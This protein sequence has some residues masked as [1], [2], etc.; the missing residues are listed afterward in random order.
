M[1][2][3]F[4]ESEDRVI[5]WE[6]SDEY[7][8]Q[9]PVEKVSINVQQLIYDA[10]SQVKFKN[11]D[12]AN[13]YYERIL[14]RKGVPFKMADKKGKMDI[15]YVF[16]E[17][18]SD[19]YDY[20]AAV[21]LGLYSAHPDYFLPYNFRCKFNQLEEIH[22]EFNIPMPPVPG[23]FKKD[24]RGLYYLSINKAWQ[25]FRNLHG[26]SPAETCAFLYD[27]APEFVTPMDSRDLPL[28]SKVWLST[29]GAWDFEFLEKSKENSISRWGGNPA[30]RRGDIILM[31][32]VSPHKC[33]HSIWRACSDGF[34]D[35][36][37]HYHGTIWI[38]GRVKTVPVPFAELKEDP[39]LSQKAAVKAHFQGPS[40]KASCTVEEYEAI[41]KI[42]KNKGQDLSVLPRIPLRDELP[43]VKLQDEHD[44]EI[45]LIEPFLERLGYKKSDWVR[46][47]PIKM[48]RGERNY[49]D[50]AIGAKT[51][52]GDES[53]R[54][55]LE[56]KYQL[57]S[58]RE[59][60]DAFMQAKSYA[61]RLQSKI[62][63]M[64]AKEGVW[65][66]PPKDESFDIKRV[67]H[68]TWG[69]LNHPDEFHELRKYIGRNEVF[70]RR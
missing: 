16:G 41:L 25:E 70:Q 14:F 36:F 9:Y 48:G 30:V 65:V 56:S 59:F 51:K 42:M 34:I 20:V 21:S 26:L 8:N 64:A 63:A 55:V 13:R 31:Y 17:D 43:Q 10:A 62:M 15:I 7:K 4:I 58:H 27:F 24:D 40:S 22:E 32:C 1:T 2:D 33:I 28:P 11:L 44:V 3:R 45:Q 19:W 12:D 47:M 61:L 54:M 23:K 60:I 6:F 52:H 5:T 39:L 69:E 46:Q 50:Y 68:K 38:C 67:I 57:S 29:G 37:F 35:P 49:P 53:A 18:D 66:F